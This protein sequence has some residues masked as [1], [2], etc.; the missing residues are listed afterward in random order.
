[1]LFKST[2]SHPKGKSLQK[3]ILEG[4]DGDEGRQK[5]KPLGLARG[6]FASRRG[7]RRC[8]CSPAAISFQDWLLLPLMRKLLQCQ[9]VSGTGSCTTSFDLF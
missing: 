3:D 2:L 1:M 9:G 4:R 5:N 6:S 7:L 8:S